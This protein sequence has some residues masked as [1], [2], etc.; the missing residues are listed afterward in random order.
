MS[1]IRMNQQWRV[2]QYL[3]IGAVTLGGDLTAH[4]RGGST[5]NPHRTLIV[6]GNGDHP[7]AVKIAALGHGIC[8]GCSA[9]PD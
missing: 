6:S 9:F 2:E 8:A 4:N 3:F 7:G 5:S 1:L